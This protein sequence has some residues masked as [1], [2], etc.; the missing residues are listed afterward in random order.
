MIEDGSIGSSLSVTDGGSRRKKKGSSSSG[1][2]K[3]SSG[4]RGGG[5]GSDRMSLLDAENEE[6][7]IERSK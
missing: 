3:N 7:R 4:S 1:S 6:V 2:K 5:A